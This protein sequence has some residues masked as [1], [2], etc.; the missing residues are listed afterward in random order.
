MLAVL[1]ISP[2]GS[3][4]GCFL[5]ALE[6]SAAAPD[7]SKALSKRDKNSAIEHL[8]SLQDQ[9]RK[10]TIVDMSEREKEAVE[11]GGRKRQGKEAG[12]YARSGK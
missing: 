11:R 2:S 3:A 8:K 4:H 1:C 5:Q 9:V 6:L 10:E 7:L 12:E